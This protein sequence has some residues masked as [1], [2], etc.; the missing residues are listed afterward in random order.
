MTITSKPSVLLELGRLMNLPLSPSLGMGLMTNIRPVTPHVPLL[1]AIPAAHAPAIPVDGFA[2]TDAI[3]MPPPGASVSITARSAV[4]SAQ[5]W[6]QRILG[7]ADSDAALAAIKEAGDRKDARAA[8]AIA[9]FMAGPYSGEDSGGLREASVMPLPATC[10]G[11]LPFTPSTKF[12][13]DKYVGRR[14]RILRAMDV[15]DIH[16]NVIRLAAGMRFIVREVNDAGPGIMPVLTL[17]E[18]RSPRTLPSGDMS[19]SQALPAAHTGDGRIMVSI[20]RYVELVTRAGVA[21]V[22][23]EEE[24]EKAWRM[25]GTLLLRDI[26]DIDKFGTDTFTPSADA[27]TMRVIKVHDLSLNEVHEDLGDIIGSAMGAAEMIKLSDGITIMSFDEQRL[28]ELKHTLTPQEYQDAIA[29]IMMRELA[30]AER[31]PEPVKD[32]TSMLYWTTA[33]FRPAWARAICQQINFLN[34]RGYDDD[35]VT[36]ICIAS[37]SVTDYGNGKRDLFAHTMIPHLMT[38]HHHILRGGDLKLQEYFDQQIAR[39]Q[40][41]A[42]YMISVPIDE[43]SDDMNLIISPQTLITVTK[44]LIDGGVAR[45]KV[46]IDSEPLDPLSEES[47]QL[48]EAALMTAERSDEVYAKTGRILAEDFD[49]FMSLAGLGHPDVEDEDPLSRA[50]KGTEVVIRFLDLIESAELVTRKPFMKPVR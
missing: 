45:V 30:Y 34:M 7:A 46:R 32:V 10:D 25:T 17:V 14:S 8:K 29:S 50:N 1:S 28:E 3:T 35:M 6:E 42:R 15:V 16:N 11:F 49:A 4:T 13:R 38:H 26:V 19:M 21:N 39:H 36:R 2:A 22:T 48:H 12:C 31:P 43:R 33:F 20:D 37:S 9:A 18:E 40:F 23:I 27:A 41:K 47:R 5:E 24:W 44:V